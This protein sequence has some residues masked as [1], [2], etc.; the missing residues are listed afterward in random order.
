MEDAV[1][2]LDDLLVNMTRA[3]LT[4][5]DA[6]EQLPTLVAAGDDQDLREVLRLTFDESPAASS[7]AISRG[8]LLALVTAPTRIL[9]SL[10]FLADDPK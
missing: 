6:G 7:E 9:A 3:G 2:S 4:S 1:D 8:E 5:Y 10:C